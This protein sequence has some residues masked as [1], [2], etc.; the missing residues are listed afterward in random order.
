[1]NLKTD[2]QISEEE[3]ILI[4]DGLGYVYRSAINKL[5]GEFALIFNFFRNLRS[6]IENFEPTKV[7]FVWEGHPKHRYDLFPEYKANRLKTASKDSQKSTKDKVK[8]ASIEVQRLLKYLPI[9]QVKHPDFEADD[10][11]AFLC[12]NMKNE[13]CT[14]ISGDSDLVQLLQKDYS[15]LKLYN[16]Q[17]KDYVNPPT[18]NY[19]LYKCLA[20]DKKSDNI[21]SVVGPKTAEKL[22]NN[23]DDLIKFLEIEENAANFRLNKELIELKPIPEDEIEFTS[24]EVD[25]DYLKSEFERMEFKSIVNDN[26][27]IN[28]K[29]TFE[30][31]IK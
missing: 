29:R 17:I 4:I 7:F 1:M 5:D 26:S 23:L 18:Y 14:I 15:K 22:V 9:T 10:C 21:P 27:W 3:H 28:F 13:K 19:L 24:P 31:L 30:D 25:F 12:E 6:T 16:Y 8:E 20:G 11:I 2:W